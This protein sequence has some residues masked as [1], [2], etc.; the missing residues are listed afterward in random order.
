MNPIEFWQNFK[1]GEE[2]EIACNFIYDGLLNLH[3]LKTLGNET[4]IFPFLYYISVGIERLLKVAVILL[5]FNDSTDVDSFEKSLIT[6]NHIDLL[7]RIKNKRLL[8]FG[9]VHVALL[10]LLS[11][12]YKTHRYDRFSLQ[13]LTSYSKDKKAFHEFLYKYLKIDIKDES[14]I[15]PVE[16]SL[17]IKKF[18]GKT[19]RK[20]TRELYTVIKETASSKNLYT[21]EISSSSSKAGKILFGE[22]PI[23]FENEDIATV[24]ALIFLMSTKESSLIDFMKSVEPLQLDP[25]LD[26]EYLQA[27]LHKRPEEM[28]GI[29]DE[30]EA[31]Y[32]DIGNPKDRL[33]MIKAIK[34][35]GITFG[36]IDE[37]GSDK[38]GG[39]NN[40]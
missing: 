36:D 4:E 3:N 28:Q 15:S 16:N 27:L 26:S 14:S 23:I 32:D 18:I 24:E 6:H 30:V 19:V 39:I 13:S 40:L 34:N 37:S 8:A 35:P 17:Q 11:T 21:E 25:G 33:G 29:I 12:F 1:L 2:Q 20:I 38:E 31:C 22:D 9:D 5:E 10:S 7:N